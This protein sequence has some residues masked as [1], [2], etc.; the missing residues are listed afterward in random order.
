MPV[1]GEL[2][3][4][5]LFMGLLP[6]GGAIGPRRALD[7]AGPDGGCALSGEGPR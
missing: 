6:E 5:E 2:A 1:V 3:A 7:E 4:D